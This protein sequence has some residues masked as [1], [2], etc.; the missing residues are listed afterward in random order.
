[1]QWYPLPDLAGIYCPDAIVFRGEEGQDY[2]FMEEPVEMAF[3]AVAAIKRPHLVRNER[4]EETLSER[5]RERT[6]GKIRTIMD[7]GLANGTWG[8]FFFGCEKVT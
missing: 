3:V 5:D 6:R 4:R 2:A 1:M 7:I 8:F